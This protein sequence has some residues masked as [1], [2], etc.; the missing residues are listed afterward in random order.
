MIACLLPIIINLCS[1]P[2][3]ARDIQEEKIAAVRCA[4]IYPDAPCLKKFVKVRPL[5][6]RAI[7]GENK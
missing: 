6:Y 1:E 5:I 4:Q 2:V 7:C 3:N